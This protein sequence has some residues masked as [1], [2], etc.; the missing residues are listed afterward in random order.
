MIY[1]NVL[2]I[3]LDKVIQKTNKSLFHNKKPKKE[4]SKNKKK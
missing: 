2:P 1:K 3:K 4:N